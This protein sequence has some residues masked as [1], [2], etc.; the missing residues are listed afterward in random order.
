MPSSFVKDPDSTLDF[1]CD[2]SAWLGEDTI[3]SSE[4]SAP[5]GI[6]V[7]A[8]SHSDTATTVWLSGGTLGSRYAVVN[9]IVTAD[10][11]AEDRTLMIHCWER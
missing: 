8:T 1:S 5:E 3:E 4:W 9:S 7:G 10:G 11:R 6:T 2:W